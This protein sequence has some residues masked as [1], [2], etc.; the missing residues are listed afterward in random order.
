VFEGAVLDGA[1]FDGAVLAAG[2]FR[3]AVLRN[4]EFTAADL[5][6]VEFDG[7]FFLGPDPL[8]QLSTAAAP[9]TFRAERF[10]ARPA[11]AAEVMALAAPFRYF[12]GPE[13]EDHAAAGTLWR[14]R[15]V[16][17]FEAD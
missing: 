8:A 12:E 9:G 16:Q 10:E 15:R 6:S 4:V 1:T 7:A 14:L 13:L 11:T 5:R 17:P 3:N 2:T